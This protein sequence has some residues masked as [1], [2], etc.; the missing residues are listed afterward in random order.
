MQRSQ[1]HPEKLE[2]FKS[3][4]ML[5]WAEENY[6]TML[7]PDFLP[8]PTSGEFFDGVKELRGRESGEFFDGVKELRGREA[9]IPDEDLVCLVGNMIT[10]E[11]LQTFQ[12]VVNIHGPRFQERD[13][14]EPDTTRRTRGCQ[15]WANKKEKNCLSGV[16]IPNEQI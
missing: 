12:I 13:T 5:S 6:R 1:L 2:A 4:E 8:D 16:Q 15:T 10:E 14:R 7:K 3:L 9:G 11:A